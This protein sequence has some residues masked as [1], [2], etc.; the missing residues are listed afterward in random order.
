MPGLVQSPGQFSRSGRSGHDGSLAAK[1]Q[2]GAP[3]AS[4]QDQR[5][6][7]N[8]AASRMACFNLFGRVSAEGMPGQC[9]ACLRRTDSAENVKRRNTIWRRNLPND[10]PKAAKLPQCSISCR[11]W[12]TWQHPCRFQV[13]VK[14]SDENKSESPPDSLCCQ[15]GF[16]NR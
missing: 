5:T 13:D 10:T 4:P 2:S 7:G 9:W 3:P 11:R 12:R 1:R 14:F 15:A 16:S 8:A 6:H